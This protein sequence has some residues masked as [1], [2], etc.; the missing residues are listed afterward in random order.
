[1]YITLF[2]LVTRLPNS[3]RSVKDHFLSLCPTELAVDLLE[4]RLLA[5]EKRIVAVGTS[6]CDPRAPFFEGCSPVPVLPTFTS[7][8]AVDL[9]GTESVGA[10]TAPSG[11]RRSGRSKGGKGAGGDGGGT[12]VAVEAAEGVG[13]EVGVVARVGAAVAVVGVEAA[14]AAA[15]GVAAAVV[16]VGVALC[17]VEAL[18]VASARSSSVLVRPCR[19]SSF[20]SGTLGVGGLGV[21]VPTF[22]SGVALFDLDYDAMLAAMYAVTINAEGDCYLCVPP[23][24]G[25]AAAA[26][27][28][29]ESAAPR[30]RESTL[31]G[32]AGPV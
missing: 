4:E 2:Y 22:T 18:V 17:S 23:D 11:R 21:L 7:V 29:S 30:A 24:P 26:L 14:A 6:R 3:L 31:L 12:V 9:V 27:G 16:L 5:A 20:V 13:V 28:A 10:V 32:S 15:V 19:P 8:V 25:I 1:M